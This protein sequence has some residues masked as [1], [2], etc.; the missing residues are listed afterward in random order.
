MLHNDCVVHRCVA[1]IQQACEQL[2]VFWRLSHTVLTSMGTKVYCKADR[3]PEAEECLQSGHAV[4]Q[5]QL[6][7]ASSA[8][9]QDTISA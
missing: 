8:G 3:K 2:R 7:V 9:P 1:S 5:L 6:L 4:Q